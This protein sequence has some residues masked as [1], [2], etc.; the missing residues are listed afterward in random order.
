MQWIKP[1]PNMVITESVTFLPGVY[2]FFDL[3]GLT[4]EGNDITI[5]GQNALFIGGQK[6][7]NQISESSEAFS[8]GYDKKSK[9]ESLGYK[10]IGIQSTNTTGVILKNIACKG[11]EIGLDLKNCSNWHIEGCD[12]SYNYHNP[13]HGWEEH[14]D[15]GGINMIG[16]HHCTLIDN[17]ATDVW[18]ALTLRNSHQNYVKNNK[19]SHTSNVGLRMW[20]ACENHI[21][22]NDFS[23]G[24]RK[25]PYEIHARDSSCVLVETASNNNKFL[26]NDMRYGGDGFF[27][28]SLNNMMSTG[29]LIK[30]NDMS[31]ANNNAIEAWDKGNAYIGNKVCSSSY[32]FWLGNS[33]DTVLID[34]EI[35]FNGCTFNNAPEAF[36]NAGI[37]VVNG[38]GTHFEVVNNYIHHNNGP[39]L[40]IR[41]KSKYPSQHWLIKNNRFEGNQ[42]DERGYVGHGIYMK[43]VHDIQLMNNEFLNNDGE[44]V[45]YDQNCSDITYSSE[46]EQVKFYLEIHQKSFY[47]GDKIK[48]K[49]SV[50]YEMIWYINNKKYKGRDLNVT[51]STP[52]LHR[53]AARINDAKYHGTA[54][55]NV[56]VLEKGISIEMKEWTSNA[57]VQY[58]KTHCIT[59]Q[60]LE[61]TG[62]EKIVEAKKVIDIKSHGSTHFSFNMLC[63]SEIIEWYQTVKGPTIT[64]KNEQ[65]ETCC[66][67]AKKGF[68]EYFNGYENESKYEWLQYAIDLNEDLLFEKEGTF[69][70]DVKFIEIAFEFNREA[71][72]RIL[73]DGFQFVTREKNKL[74]EVGDVTHANVHVS[75]R[76]ELA[77]HPL[78]KSRFS[79]DMIERWISSGEEQPFYEIHFK[80]PKLVNRLSFNLYESI[81]ETRCSSHEGLPQ[82]INIELLGSDVVLEPIVASEINITFDTVQVKGLRLS[83]ETKKII[84]IYD[85]CWGHDDLLRPS[86]IKGMSPVHLDAVEIMLAYNLASGSKPQDLNID[87]CEYTHDVTTYT[88]IKSKKISY[89]EISFFQP[90]LIE[91]NAALD[92]SKNY[93]FSLHQDELVEDNT[94]SY[95]R[96]CAKGIEE[97]SGDY[98]YLNKSE[99]VNKNKLA[100]GDN[101]LNT[102]VNGI[103]INQSFDDELIGNRLGI[104]GLEKLYQKLDYTQIYKEQMLA[105][106]KGKLPKG[107][108][109]VSFDHE[110]NCIILHGYGSVN[111][112]GLSYDVNGLK[113]VNVKTGK[114]FKLEVLNCDFFDIHA[115]LT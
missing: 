84:G 34:N 110:V 65:G 51:L 88:S 10:G 62:S 83:F 104:V 114:H 100:W 31:F 5:D 74:N 50:D 108:Y 29:N 47:V 86:E 103:K 46:K 76:Q 107:L 58:N 101:W 97:M 26:K 13:D 102:F 18:N 33:D 53:I 92:M 61:L 48:V 21:E 66:F 17:K 60:A 44:Q 2:N 7:M 85:L 115:Y 113:V 109:E 49:P 79:G 9:N 56:Y 96:W 70:E 16:C 27:I 99:H 90:F 40:A 19:F 67:K 72:Y 11:F 3:N 8:Y 81:E 71:P 24:L 98:G 37:A 91:M 38:S 6:K 105:L 57:H 75:S 25:E 1:Y 22:E 43:H 39:G 36:G 112:D 54:Y 52:G 87:L 111:L 106:G 73:L 89:D 68:F 78:N 28:R 12:F 23:Y 30:D 4:V 20:Q 63:H 59:E 64:F 69:I 35:A 94:K 41:N 32:G 15:L 42:T 95:Y 82:K 80:S 55:I 14:D 45:Y 77:F 93:F